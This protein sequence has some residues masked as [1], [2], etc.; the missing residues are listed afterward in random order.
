MADTLTLLHVIVVRNSNN[1]NSLEDKFSVVRMNLS[2][3]DK[4]ENWTLRVFSKWLH[5]HIH[6]RLDNYYNYKQFYYL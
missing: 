1:N 4:L 6:Y 3:Q 2:H 5:H